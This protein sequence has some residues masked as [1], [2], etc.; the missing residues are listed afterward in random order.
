MFLRT[1]GQSV[2]KFERLQS[3]D[4]RV[5]SGKRHGASSFSIIAFRAGEPDFPGGVF[6]VKTAR[7]LLGDEWNKRTEF[8]ECGANIGHMILYLKVLASNPVWPPPPRHVRG[9][10]RMC[11]DELFQSVDQQ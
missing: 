8:F 6:G 3:V 1:I 11:I 5:M 10:Q 4:E 9:V 2:K 7:R